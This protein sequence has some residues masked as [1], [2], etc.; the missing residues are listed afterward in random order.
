MTKLIVYG[1]LALRFTSSNPMHRNGMNAAATLASYT[2]TART[3]MELRE[4]QR[5]I[6][7]DA[8]KQNALIVL[9][10]GTGSIVF[11]L[12]VCELLDSQMAVTF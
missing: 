9:P 1:S 11:P 7:Q 3:N 6:V 12:L 5:K 4:Y 2:C 8:D 10:T